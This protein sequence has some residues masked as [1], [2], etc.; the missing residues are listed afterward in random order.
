MPTYSDP[1]SIKEFP[2]NP[3]YGSGCFRRR[4]RLTGTHGQVLAELEDSCHGFR[5]TIEHDGEVITAVSAETLRIPFNT[6]AGATR[7]IQALVGI[8]IGSDPKTV[9]QS[10]NPFSNCT[11]LFDLSVLAI[12]H[13]ARGQTTRQFDVVVYDEQGDEPADAAVSLDGKEILRFKTRQWELLSPPELQGKP[14]FR[15]FAAWANDYFQGDE[16]EAAFVLQKGYFVS[17]ARRIDSPK[18]EG[19]RG[20]DY[21]H[22]ANACHTYSEGVVEQALR[23]PD[24]VRDFTDSPEQLLR[25]K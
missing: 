13:A 9:N 4:I 1:S 14:L 21:P 20:T 22:I 17:S 7:P 8:A 25:F 6:C 24:T 5:A 10:V 15:G 19:S 12:A 18:I 16:R 11:H 3:D 23:L 2:A